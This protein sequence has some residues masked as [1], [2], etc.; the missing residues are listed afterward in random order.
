MIF[1][2]AFFTALAQS[3]PAYIRSSFLGEFVD[4]EFIGLVFILAAFSTLVVINFLPKFISKYSNYK[5]AICLLIL[6]ILALAGIIFAD[7]ARLITVFFIILEIITALLWVSMDL[8]VER[9]TKNN[10]TGKVRAFYFTVMNFAWMLSPVI[11][12]YLVGE[13]NYKMIYIAAIVLMLLVL[14]ILLVRKEAFQEQVK[15]E[16]GSMK[17]VAKKVWQDSSLQG[18]FGA[19]FLLAFFYVIA[20]LFMPIYLHEYIGFSWQTIGYIFT[21]MLLPFVLLQIPAGYIAD[22]KHNEKQIFS[23]GFVIMI[24]STLLFFMFRGDNPFIWA[25]ILFIGRCGAALV[26]IMKE[27]YF[28][29]LIDVE[30]VDYINFFR[31]IRPAAYIVASALSMLMLKF[32]AIEFLFLFLAI[33]LLGS[34]YF[35]WKMK[36]IEV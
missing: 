2:S 10:V 9:F 15:F 11:A 12:G 21:F 6:N 25:L 16:H 29:K 35:I 20:V 17:I 14:I 13:N 19:A 26:E 28:F 23:A 18:V 22:K 4:V 1:L 36:K 33:V 34:F 27:V 3:I 5:V 32:F 7:S 31:N 24:L 30:D 8:F